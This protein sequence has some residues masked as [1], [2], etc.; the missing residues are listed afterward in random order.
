LKTSILRRLI[1][2]L[3]SKIKS[4]PKEMAKYLKRKGLNIGS[5]CEVFPDVSFGSEPYLIKLGD[6]VKITSGVRFI[7][8]DGGIYVL[9][10][11]N[12]A[13]N[14]D[15][16]GRIIVGNNVFI[17]IN[18]IILPNVTIGD[19][20]IIGAGS[21]VSKSIPRD[22]FAVGV[23][24]RVIKSL[25]KYYADKENSIDYTKNMSPVE[26][27]RYLLKKHNMEYSHLKNIIL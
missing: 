22:S 17:G 20:C 25:D 9:R 6:K 2:F 26:K 11:I 7:T 4:D 5:D 23:P 21:V 8:H 24:A 18:S 12:H 27:R 3:I 1:D 10:N 15:L 14:L 16:I 19:N 13:P